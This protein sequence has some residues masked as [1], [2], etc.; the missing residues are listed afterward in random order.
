MRRVC[1]QNRKAAKNVPQS[2]ITFPVKSGLHPKDTILPKKQPALQYVEREMDGSWCEEELL[3]EN[4]AFSTQGFHWL[5]SSQH[6]GENHLV[7]PR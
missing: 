5:F 1:Y 2:K 7:L 6:G 4:L 3:L